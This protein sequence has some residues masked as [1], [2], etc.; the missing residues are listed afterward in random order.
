MQ[1][2]R[3]QKLVGFLPEHAAEKTQVLSILEDE[4][5]ALLRMIP[6]PPLVLFYLGDPQALANRAI[7]IVGA[8]KC[9]TVE[10]LLPNALLQT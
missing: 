8:R 4:F 5:P 10:R 7:V 3:G 9:T 1:Q 2:K 6:D